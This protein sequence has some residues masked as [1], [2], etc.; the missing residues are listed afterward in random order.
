V[1]ES[2]PATKAGRRTA[3]TRADRAARDGLPDVGVLVSSRYSTLHPGYFVIFSGVYDS[4]ADAESTL[5]AA[6]A[7][8]FSAAYV[9]QI[10]Q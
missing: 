10:A 3:Q 9:R 7:A 2:L 1:L 8:G 5:R 6:T 4:R